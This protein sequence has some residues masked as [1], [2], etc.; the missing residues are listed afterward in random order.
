MR[1]V[2]SMQGEEGGEVGWE[3]KKKKGKIIRQ[4]KHS[5][6]WER[7]GIKRRDSE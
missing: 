6:G 1:K 7:G 4:W 5:I 2:E 3:R